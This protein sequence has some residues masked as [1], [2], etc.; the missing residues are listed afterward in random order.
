MP[1]PSTVAANTPLKQVYLNNRRAPVCSCGAENL[2]NLLSVTPLPLHA[3]TTAAD[4]DL[5]PKHF[6][7]HDL[8]RQT[9][10]AV[11]WVK[12]AMPAADMPILWQLLLGCRVRQRHFTAKRTLQAQRLAYQGSSGLLQTEWKRPGQHTVSQQ[13]SVHANWCQFLAN[14][15]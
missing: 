12:K 13:I 7:T 2:C 5:A 4:H 14:I 15:H 1:S 3:C 9:V 11:L 6:T 10:N 8:W